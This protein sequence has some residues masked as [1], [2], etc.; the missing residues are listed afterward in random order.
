MKYFKAKIKE[1]IFDESAGKEKKIAFNVLVIAE[2]IDAVNEIVSTEMNGANYELV[3][4]VD[5][6]ISD[7]YGRAAN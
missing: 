3:S 2:S 5:S 6:G 4:I 1:I 7:I